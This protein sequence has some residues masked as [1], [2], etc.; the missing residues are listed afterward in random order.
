M[1]KSV[2]PL[3]LFTFCFANATDVNVPSKFS[4]ATFA[5]SEYEDNWQNNSSQSK[6][7][8]DAL[9]NSFKKNYCCPVKVPT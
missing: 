5:I 8:A 2:L 3:I 9:V 6:E 7:T 4:I 1:K